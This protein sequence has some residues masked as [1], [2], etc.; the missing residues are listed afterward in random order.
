MKQT[1]KQVI[2]A[3][4]NLGFSNVNYSGLEKRFYGDFQQYKS[5][6]NKCLFMKKKKDS[7]DILFLNP[8]EY[9]GLIL[10]TINNLY[11]QNVFFEVKR[12][13]GFV[14]IITDFECFIFQA[15][16]IFYLKPSFDFVYLNGIYDLRTE[17]EKALI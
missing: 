15:L 9:S 3:L 2:E 5:I 17:K 14:K 1:K 8:A 10:T 4:T 7:D 6:E 12:G 13:Y 16:G 11:R